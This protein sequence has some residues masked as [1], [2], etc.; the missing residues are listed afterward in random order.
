[1]LECNTAASTT[2]TVTLDL[3]GPTVSI[4]NLPDTPKNSAFTITITF[5]EVVTGFVLGDISLGGTAIAE[6]TNLTQV[7]TQ[8]EY[9][10]EII[11]TRS[12][13]LTI[14]VPANVVQDAVTNPNTASTSHTVSIDLVRPTVTITGAPTT[15]QNGAFPITITFNEVVT[16]F[17]SNDISLDGTASAMVALN[18]SGTS[19]TATITP[20]GSGNLTIA[21]PENV[22]EDTATNGN[23]ASTTHTVSIDVDRPTVTISNVPPL[24]RNSAFPITIEFS[25]TVTGFQV[26]EIS[27]TGTATATATLAGIGALY[28]ATITPTGSGT[29]TIA[30]RANV[31]EDTATNGNT[32]STTHTVPID[33]DRPTVTISNV[34]P[35][36]RNSAFPITI[37]F[38]EAVTG[39]Q[40]NEI[41]LTGTGTARATATLAGIGDSYTT[42]TITP[43]GS[44]ILTI[45]VPENVAEDAATNGNTAS[46][47]H[48]VPVDVD[49]PTVTIFK[50]PTASAKR[51]VSDNESHS[52]K[53]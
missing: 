14:Q 13:N 9:T 53:S 44:G 43:T 5:N 26:N 30:V 52:M 48:T 19:Y 16:D 11:P 34:P 12:G 15:P 31:A 17:V 45:A 18:G 1:M 6:V 32:A 49:R 33:V 50:C 51:C 37:E 42:A 25:E 41:S 7:V 36:P 21:V 2:K 3:T 47:T 38:S 39:F 22:A 24:P 46:T 27:L 28:T 8:R 40:V 10:A 35:L 29:L 23:T 20:T 4:T